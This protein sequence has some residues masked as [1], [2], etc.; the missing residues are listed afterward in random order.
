MK[1]LIGDI[2]SEWRS[3]SM[4]NLISLVVEKWMMQMEKIFDIQNCSN[5]QKISFATLYWK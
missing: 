5:D 1:G 4:M 3:R 2:E